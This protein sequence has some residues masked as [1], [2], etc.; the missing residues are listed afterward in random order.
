MNNARKV[1]QGIVRSFIAAVTVAFVAP[2]LAE[3]LSIDAD[4]TLAE[5]TDWR[6]YDNVTVASGVSLDLGGQK[7]YV[8]S[9]DGSGTVTNSVAGGELHID[10][11]ADTSVTISSLELVGSLRLVKEGAGTLNAQ[12]Y[13]Q[14]Y[15]G[16]NDVVQGIL[17]Y[18][19]SSKD[20]N[21]TSGKSPFGSV[22]TIDV[23]S[24]GILDPYGSYNWGNHTINLYGGVI[25]NTVACAYNTNKN[26]LNAIINV[27]AD[28]D[29]A[30]TLDYTV[31]GSIRLNGFTL[32]IR[33]GSGKY[34]DFVP[35]ITGGGKLSLI[36]GGW[37][38]NQISAVTW[39]GVDLIGQKAAFN[40]SKAISLRD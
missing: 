17:R 15:S 11:P 19:C 20:I 31:R 9:I 35:S 3:D 21:S 25:S 30:T 18:Y 12:K 34:L 29:I 27:Y 39:S 2:V 38:R 37:L 14:S 26:G 10:V 16:G 22:M 5:D 13:P 36:A 40:L 8:K 24:G 7:L 6:S 1:V 32:G 4:I 33:I 23:R 28:S